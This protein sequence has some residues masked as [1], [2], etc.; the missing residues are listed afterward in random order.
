MR[1]FMTLS[2]LSSGSP[3]PMSTMF[4]MGRP[5]S[6][7]E[8]MTSSRISEGSRPLIRPPMVEAQ[9]AQPWRQPTCVEMQTV[10]PW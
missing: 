6:F 10:L 3:M 1:N 8:N 9:K 4:E 5:D 2:K 7:C